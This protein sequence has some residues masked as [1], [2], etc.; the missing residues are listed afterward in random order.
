MIPYPFL[1]VALVHASKLGIQS[2]SL[3]QTLGFN[4]T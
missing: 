2:R 4:V 1:L 3:L